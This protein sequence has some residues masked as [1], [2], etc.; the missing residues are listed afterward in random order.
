MLALS[1]LAACG[2]T[3]TPE[4][5]RPVRMTPGIGAE[6]ADPT[7]DASAEPTDREPPTRVDSP[8]PPPLDPAE[9][10]ALEPEQIIA[11]IRS[12]VGAI[13]LC[14][15]RSPTESGRIEIAWR[16]ARDGS[17]GFARVAYSSMRDERVELCIVDVM[18]TTRFP[19]PGGQV[20]VVF[21]FIFGDE[22]PRSPTPPSSTP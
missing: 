16:I 21:P 13:R 2:A 22:P 3:P 1:A 20:D 15:E 9:T 6:P 14:Y 12:I 7:V 5:H 19:E 8:E 4:P 10:G 11:V 18:S 17:V